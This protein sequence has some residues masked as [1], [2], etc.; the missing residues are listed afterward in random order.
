MR[1]TTS[2][3]SRGHRDCAP[4]FISGLL[5]TQP[6]SMDRR[7][8][9]HQRTVRG[10]FILVV[11]ATGSMQGRAADSAIPQPPAAQCASMAERMAK[12]WP[13]AT[14]QLLTAQW[15]A[16][17]SAPF[18]A[19]PGA[20]PVTL[21][22]PAHCEMT[23][24]AQERVGEGNQHYAIHFHLRL[25]EVWN[26][27]FLFQGGGGSDGVIGDALGVYSALAQPALAQGFAVVSQ[28]AGHDNSTNN[29]PARG[30]VLVFGFDEQARANYGHASL[31]I[32]SQ[33]AKAAIREFYGSEARHSYFV[34]C[35]KGGNEGMALAQRYPAE[36]DG[37]VANAPAISLPRAGIAE[38]WDTQAMASVVRESPDAPLAFA[39]LSK[40]F[41]DK[42]FA[43]VHDAIV[44]VCDADDGLKD[45]IIN[46]FARC[47]T[48]RLQPQLEALRCPADKAES[49]LS[50]A[51]IAA[52]LRVMAGPHDSAGQPLYS[53]WPWDAGIG[54]AGWRMWKIG[55]YTAMP[56]SL[57]VILGGASLASNFTTPPTPQGADPQS[58]FDY[59]MQFDFDRDAPKI[60]ATNAQFPRSAW[61][62][63]AARSTDLAGFRARHGKMIVVQGVSDPVFSIND[64]IAWWREVDQ[65][66]H[67][68]AAQFVRVFPVPGMNHCGGGDAT[69]QFDALQPLMRWVEQ[70][71]A[72]ASV[73]AKTSPGTTQAQRSRPLCPYPA[74]AHYKGTG[75]P[76]NADSFE[77][78]KPAR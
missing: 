76:A 77:C 39:K 50:A 9:L 48:A 3:A 30:G 19:G 75:D 74:F 10:M 17:A 38:A 24:V 56:P 36:F 46:D 28:D 61:E 64:T 23:A 16:V 73:A 63:I 25:P 42:D 55:A 65:K 51:Q 31:P 15:Q 8:R 29:D 4:R 13:D 18:R 68:A 7:R 47:T 34:G 58:L 52:L 72:P 49:C 59:L 44:S 12:H 22:V 67:G 60:Y 11:A 66:E 20:P 32:V 21:E 33:A 5:H 71:H 43:L 40:S 14:T 53:D 69:D 27:R 45:G 78:H 35:S 6:A 57:N 54:S 1:T 41:S 26:G 2:M 70:G 62:D 37:I